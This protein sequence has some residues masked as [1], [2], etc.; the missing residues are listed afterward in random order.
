MEATREIPETSY[1][2]SRDA[3]REL[4]AESR[5]KQGLPPK[6]EDAATLNRVATLLSSPNEL[7][8]T[9]VEDISTPSLRTRDGDTV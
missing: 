1:G 2:L 5:D 7:D 8:P 4:V 9:R 6:V 3:L